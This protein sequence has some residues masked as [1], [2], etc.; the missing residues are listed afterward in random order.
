[1]TCNQLSRVWRNRSCHQYVEVLVDTRIDNLCLDVLP[2]VV[3]FGE[4]RSDT[5]MMVVDFE[6]FC[7]SWLTDVETQND[8]FLAQQGEADGHIRC[9]ECLSFA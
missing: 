4:Q 6:E 1:M 8:G 5:M 9:C 7:Q 3:V 2:C